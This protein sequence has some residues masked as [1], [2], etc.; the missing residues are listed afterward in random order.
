MSNRSVAPRGGLGG[1]LDVVRN[2]HLSW[3]LLRDER[4]ALWIKGV[5]FLSLAYLI[6]PADLLPDI[7]LGLGQLDDVAVILLGLR[8]FIALCPKELVAWH[9]ER[10]ASGLSGDDKAIDAEYRI[11]DEEPDGPSAS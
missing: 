6:W 11:V 9:R 4:V 3:R 10:L 8:A 7:A 2:A 5:P 1:L